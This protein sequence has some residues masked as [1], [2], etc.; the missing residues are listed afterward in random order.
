[1]KIVVDTSVIIAVLVN[2]PVKKELIK[3]TKNKEIIV[4]PSV[5]WEIGNAFSAMLKRK[6]IN[7]SESLKALQAYNSISIRIVEI[8]MEDSLLVSDKLNIYAYDAYVISCA[9]KYHC[10]LISLDIGLVEA[11]KNIGVTILEIEK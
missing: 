2:E 8:E 4:P 9:L 3:I 6:R 11:A 7:I 5:H 1:M 10:P